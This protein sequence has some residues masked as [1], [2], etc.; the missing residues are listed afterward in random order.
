M[1]GPPHVVEH[2][3]D[4]ETPPSIA[5]VEA[6][7]VLEDVDPMEIPTDVGFVLHEEIDPNALDTILSD[8]TGD[9]ETVISF[10]IDTENTYTIEISDDGRITVRHDHVK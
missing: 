3:Y 4:T 5:V 8:G 2:E 1:E 7:S 10:D 9:G 6:I